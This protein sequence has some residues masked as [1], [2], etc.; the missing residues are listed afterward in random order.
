MTPSR[1]GE[2]EIGLHRSQPETCD[3]ELRVTD[4]GTDA[5]LAPARGQSRIS[6][7]ELARL[8]DLPDDYGA[9]LAAA[10]FSDQTIREFWLKNKVSFES[11]DY[12]CACGS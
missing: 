3:V 9:L 8:C 7:G 5:E 4:P 6:L 10:V 2:I 11:R 12:F 1:Y